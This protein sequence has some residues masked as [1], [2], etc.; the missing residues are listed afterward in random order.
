M[1]RDLINKHLPQALNNQLSDAVSSFKATRKGVE[2]VYDPAEDTYSDGADVE[3]TGRGLFS[4]YTVEEILAA[5]IDVTDVKLWCLQ[6]EVTDT[7]K[8]DD[9][10]IRASGWC[11]RVISVGQDPVS[12]GWD[13][14]LRGIS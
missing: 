9:V 2:G 5:Q 8:V 1:I 10:V 6:S 7:P 12:A 4:N 14:Q 11:G 3:Y 13:I